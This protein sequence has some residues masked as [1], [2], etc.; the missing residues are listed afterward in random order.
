MNN[1]YRTQTIE[2]LKKIFRDKSYSNIVI[3]N[4]MKNVEHSFLSLYRKSVLGVIENLIYI[5]WI[6]NEV[7]VTKTKKMEIDVLTLLRLAVYQIFFLDKSH[8]NIVVNE[9][10]QYIKDKGNVRG[11]KFVNAILRNILRSKDALTAKIN[12]LPEV[13][14]LSVKYSYP[15][16]L[17]VKWKKQFGSDVENVLIANNTEAPLEIRVNTLKIQRDELIKLLE[18]KGMRVYKCKYADKG[19]VIE[20]P[21]EIDKIKEYKDGFFSIQSESSMLS[22]QI[23][24]PKENSLVIDMCAA[25]GGKTLNAAEIMNNTGKIISR[26]IYPG[27]LRLIENEL[28]RLGIQNVKVEEYDA[29]KLDESL[30]EKADYVIADVPCTGL[31]IIRRKPEIKY[32]KTDKELND[33]R[34]I[35]YK[36]LENASK[37]IKASGELVYSTCTT[38]PEENFEL[39][40][41][42][43]KNNKGYT[44]TDISENIH[45]NFASAKNGYVEIYPHLHGMDGFFIAKIKKI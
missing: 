22:G 41:R 34:E 25:P 28:K 6:I 36:I 10:V 14:Y 30:I 32:S 7:S 23:L 4:D 18:E 9:S 27:K 39:I 1:N 15:R 45:G 3:N 24:N 13:E 26:D 43:L 37:Y 31:G 21:F 17:V 42:F 29:T 44:L 33:I 40:N 35:Q 38:N 12:E 5:D 8:E 16:E 2:T 19:L 20:N 11:S